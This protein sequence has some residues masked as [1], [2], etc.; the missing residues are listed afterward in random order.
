M[1]DHEI[2]NVGL[3]TSR[4]PDQSSCVVYLDIIMF[5]L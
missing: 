3:P 2:E 4:I 1:L 5:V